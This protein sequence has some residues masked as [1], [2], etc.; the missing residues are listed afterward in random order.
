MTPPSCWARERLA[1]ALRLAA[2]AF[3]LAPSSAF[4]DEAHRYRSEPG[5]F[6]VELPA[7]SASVAEMEGSKFSI[8]DND[9]RHTAF[10]H[11]AEFAV[12]IHDIPRFAEFLLTSRYIL[13]RTVEGMFED[14]GARGLASVDVERHGA[15]AREVAF[16][17]PERDVVGELLVVL[18]DERL[19][20]VTVRHPRSVEPPSTAAR[21]FE[22]FYFWRE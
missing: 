1:G 4:G 20:L 3:A 16:E 5:R 19:Y 14:I 21:F 2:A 22:S 13:D 17:I 18:A 10:A 7:R 9:V 15:P 12:E 6:H 11:G 8:T